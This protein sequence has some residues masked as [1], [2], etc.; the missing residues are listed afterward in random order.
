MKKFSKILVSLVAMLTIPMTV[1]AAEEY[2]KPPVIT[3]N[4]TG[5]VKTIFSEGSITIIVIVALIAIAAII[6]L[7]ARKKK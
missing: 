6:V 1:F 3:D 2:S 7:L 4:G 5:Y